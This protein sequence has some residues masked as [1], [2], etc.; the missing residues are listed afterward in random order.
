[1]KIFRV[2]PAPQQAALRRSRLLLYVGSL[3]AAAGCFERRSRLSCSLRH[4]MPGA[5]TRSVESPWLA[6]EFIA[7]S[8][9]LLS[10]SRLRLYGSMPVVAP[11]NDAT[12]KDTLQWLTL[13]WNVC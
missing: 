12:T 10:G 2:S 11:C 8:R 3:S 1:M 9:L 6:M 13:E 5:G 4:S 7:D